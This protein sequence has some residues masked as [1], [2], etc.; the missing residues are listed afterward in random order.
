ME[1]PLSSDHERQE[2]MRQDRKNKTV[3]ELIEEII[4][5]HVTLELREITLKMMQSG[6]RFQP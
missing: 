4:R 6:A 5:L 2:Q 3:Q 1:V